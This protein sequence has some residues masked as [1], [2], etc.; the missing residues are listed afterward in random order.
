MIYLPA[1]LPI[2]QDASLQPISRFVTC[3]AKRPHA[4]RGNDEING[5]LAP[6]RFGMHEMIVSSESSPIDVNSAVP[7]SRSLPAGI[8]ALKPEFQARRTKKMY[9]SQVSQYFG[10]LSSCVHAH[11]Y[12][13]TLQLTES[14]VE[15]S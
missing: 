15:A 14:E 11:K 9:S 4:L 6:A 2:G 1:I 5:E 3:C 12:T 7:E 10:S 8:P 13:G